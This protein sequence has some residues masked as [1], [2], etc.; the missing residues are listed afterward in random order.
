MVYVRGVAAAQTFDFTYDLSRTAML[1]GATWL[2][3]GP[4]LWSLRVSG[5]NLDI[6]SPSVFVSEQGGSPVFFHTAREGPDGMGWD[7]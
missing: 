3:Q 6:G 7:G 2:T 4:G 5:S 1:T